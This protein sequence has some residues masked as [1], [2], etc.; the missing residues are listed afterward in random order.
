MIGGLFEENMI[1]NFYFIVIIVYAI[2][3]SGCN[4]FVT[5]TTCYTGSGKIT[6]EE[7][8]VDS[9]DELDVQGPVTI[10][11]V[12]QDDKK[13]I[14][15]ADDNLMEHIKTSV[16]RNRLTIQLENCTNPTDSINI[17][18]NYSTFKRIY[19]R[20]SGQLITED[21]L[22]SEDIHVIMEDSFSSSLLVKT[23]RIAVSLI[24]SGKVN[25]KGLGTIQSI[26]ID[27]SGSCESLLT[28]ESADIHI[29]GSG[30]CRVFATKELDVSLSGS[31]SV[32]YKGSPKISS[33]ITGSGH[34][35][36]LD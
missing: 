8:I 10:H 4:P 1:K 34:I 3:I 35:Y 27:A 32:F 25:L 19:L 12:H 9:F 29:A 15:K 16:R 23:Q 17:T 5:E 2:V 20:G 28:S 33:S 21:T 36:K 24:G 26:V 18:I 31:G 6:S 22:H 30:N 14:I 7:R 11:L 13:V